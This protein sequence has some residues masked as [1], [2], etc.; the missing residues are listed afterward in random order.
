MTC[1]LNAPPNEVADG[2]DQRNFPGALSL[3]V[4]IHQAT[5]RQGCLAADGPDPIVRVD[6]PYPVSAD[7]ADAGRG[8]Y[9]ENDRVTPALVAAR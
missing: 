2:I 7:F 6:I 8:S 1:K 5:G 4:L 9:F 3:G